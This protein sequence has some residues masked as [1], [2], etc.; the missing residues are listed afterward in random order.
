MLIPLFN[1]FE[2]LYNCIVGLKNRKGDLMKKH[3]TI[4]IATTIIVIACS[5]YFCMASSH[6]NSIKIF[7]NDTFLKTDVDPII[8]D[9]RT[10]VPIRSIAE[11]L[12]LSLEYNNSFNEIYLRTPDYTPRPI[13][14]P[15]NLS[16]I[17]NTISGNNLLNLSI[18]EI[19][20]AIEIGKNLSADELDD[21]IYVL[22]EFNDD[23]TFIDNLFGDV[24]FNTPFLEIIKKANKDKNYSLDNA[25]SYLKNYYLNSKIDFSFCLYGNGDNFYK[26]A[27]ISLI[28]DLTVVDK[29]PVK[30]LGTLTR[31]GKNNYANAFLGT[32][33]FDF[34][35]I[36]FSKQAILK[37]DYIDGISKSFFLNFKEYM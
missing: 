1:F 37:I 9:G 32:V 2:L 23:S 12:G 4:G 24:V 3:I 8:I 17:L 19:N 11:A 21:Y 34:S 26:N 7:I 20:R 29:Y 27:Y 22:P 6:K 15:D 14:T 30:N 16:G 33:S 10:L 13:P 28:Q 5:S 31:D 35:K 18:S 25:I 36:D